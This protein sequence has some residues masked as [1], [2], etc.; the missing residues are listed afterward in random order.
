MIL[1]K[2]NLHHITYSQKEEL[3][4][5]K[6]TVI[7]AMLVFSLIFGTESF[8]AGMTGSGTST[9]SSTDKT[10]S[11]STIGGNVNGLGTTGMYGSSN[12]LGNIPT[13]SPYGTGTSA[14]GTGT[15]STYSPSPTPTTYSG[16]SS[17]SYGTNGTMRGYNYRTTATDTTNNG[18]WGW[19]GLLGLLGL[20]GMRNNNS[21]REEHRSGNKL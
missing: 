17:T 15:T 20:I 21:N 4:L 8:A 7:T 9:T 18:S 12:V 3:Y 16:T 13:T 11:G 2:I 5:K 1:R 10:G 19:L 6:L 14:Y